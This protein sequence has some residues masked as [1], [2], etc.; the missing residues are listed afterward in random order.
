MMGNPAK[1]M[2]RM[3]RHGHR[4]TPRPDGAMIRPESG[5]QYREA[6]DVLRC[7]GLNELAPLPVELTKGVKSCDDFKR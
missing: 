5:H 6:S 3:S 1:Q 7:G 2:G 4:L